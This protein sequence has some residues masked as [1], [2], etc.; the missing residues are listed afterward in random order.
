MVNVISM[1]A[2]REGP[3]MKTAAL[4][5]LIKCIAS[6]NDGRILDGFKTAMWISG[7]SDPLSGLPSPSTIK[8]DPVSASPQRALVTPTMICRSGLRENS[9]FA[10]RK[11][12]F[13]GKVVQLWE[14]FLLRLY[15]L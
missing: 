9:I 8:T 2:V 13:Y 1:S 14:P 5:P 10:S 12:F 6:G 4:V 11:I 15:L 7:S 3:V